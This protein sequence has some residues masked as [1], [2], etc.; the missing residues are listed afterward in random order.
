MKK[1]IN[2]YDPANREVLQNLQGNILKSHGR[3]HTANIFIDGKVGK[4][5]EV[6]KWI[7]L[8][9]LSG[10][11][12]S[13]YDQLRDIQTWK[14]KKIDGGTFACFHISYKGYEY[15]L[16]ADEADKR[17]KS[18]ALKGGMQNAALNDN[19]ADFE[20]GIA[21][22]SH[23]L[24]II[25]DNDPNVIGEQLGIITAQLQHI[26]TIRFVQ[27]GD[28]I[29]NDAGAGIEHFG[30]VD[31]V[32]QPLFF[33]D[34]L[35]K[36]RKENGNPAKLTFDPS[37]SVSLVLVDDPYIRHAHAYGSYLVFRKLEQDVHGFKEAEKELGH[38]L[39]LEG[40]DIERAGAM[41]IGRFE[42]GTPVQ[43][44]AEAGMLNNSVANDF[45]YVKGDESKCPFHGHTRKTNPRSD[46]GMAASKSHIMARRGIPYGQRTD[47]PN[48]GQIDN[49]PTGGVGL[50]FMS[51]QADISNQFEVIQR[52]WA[53][54]ERFST[55]NEADKVG[56]DLIIGQ[57][58]S[59]AKGAYAT[60]W[61]KPDSIKQFA[62]DKFV[63]TR[64]GGYYFAPS[65]PFLKS[66]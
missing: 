19:L 14:T 31:G 25:G 49:K 17:T 61:G 55:F 6:K 51:Y 45:D 57:G 50:L 36:Y 65:L 22:E 42:D 12:Q 20:E 59:A 3:E 4:E 21:T 47:G 28:A 43:M 52:S 44:S 39:K 9:A 11:I 41:I 63:T 64:G 58:D 27:R 24:L 26:A 1:L 16:G 30:Y 54:D 8:L 37:A 23:F 34:E 10:K 33:E 35:V 40:E 7:S 46:I 5:K 56:L 32:S 2:Q 48:D 66:L 13:C 18:I 15:L 38:K 60:E 29:K 53:N 62:F